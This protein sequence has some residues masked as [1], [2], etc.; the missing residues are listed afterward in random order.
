MRKFEKIRE[1]YEELGKSSSP[2]EVM[3]AYIWRGDG[4]YL[5]LLID[6]AED[7]ALVMKHSQ[8]P[9]DGIVLHNSSIDDFCLEYDA[10][11]NGWNDPEMAFCHYVYDY[12]TKTN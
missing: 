5:R 8:G 3:H 4:Y 12:L 11:E 6:E 1:I 9:D 10:V 7:M 2:D